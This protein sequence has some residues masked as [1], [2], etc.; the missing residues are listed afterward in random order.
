[1][2]DLIFLAFI[3]YVL[4]LGLKRPFLW[5]LLY[6]YIDIL[7]PQRI[8]YS[9]IT[10]LP[11]SL[12]AF[13]AAFGGWLVLD[14]K[15]GG[16]FSIRQGLLLALL[17]Y[18]WWSTGNADF[19]E[20]AATKW[21]WVWKALLFAIFLPF[22]LTTR[23]RIEALALMLVL[24]IATIVIGAGMKTVLGGGGYDSLNFFVDDNS[25]IYES[26]TLATVAIGLIPMIWWFTRHGTILKPHWM[27][28]AFAAALTF[29]CLLVPIGTEARTGL[30]CIA[31][32]GVLLLRYTRKRLLFIAGAGML[33]LVALPF[34]P[35][36]YYDRMATIAEPGG[37]ESAS[38][39]MAVW[40]W[41]LDYVAEK[42]LG[43]GFDSFRA[44]RFAYVMP[45]K[46]VS[47]NTTSVTYKQVV[48]EGRAFH[49]SV[50]E[51]LGEQ[52]W[53]GLAIWLSLHALGLSQMERIYRRWK[54]AQGEDEAWIAPFAAA[55]QMGALIYLVGALFQGIGYQPV[56]LML[57]GLQIGLNSYCARID[58]AQRQHERNER[59]RAAIGG[60]MRGAVAA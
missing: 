17:V 14:R 15:E 36:S 44:N 52:G 11:V 23:V 45:V 13:A 5:V 21:E 8:G 50:F 27:V 2:M 37:D 47:G 34:L 57:V 33:G 18:C 10:T 35:Q 41:T 30:L 40:Q 42:P 49:S 32:L 19:P 7:A 31:A 53:P 22:T 24:A 48:D 12:I 1:M 3:F 29:A 9:L 54:G 46:E 43:G 20:D 55:L 25:G 51:L 56:M 4:L 6:V 26:S 39:R 38:T 59:R 28:T 60:K 16:R 58:S